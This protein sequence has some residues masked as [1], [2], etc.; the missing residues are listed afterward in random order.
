MLIDTHAHLNIMVKKKF[1]VPLTSYE[2][3]DA[4]TII[5]ECAHEGVTQFINVGT[6]LVESQNCIQ[7]AKKYKEVFAVVGIHPND[8][9]SSWHSDFKKIT[10]LIKQQEENRIVGIGECGLD[11]HYP[12][13]N[14][15]RQKDAFKAHIELALSYDLP[16]VVHTRD[17]LEETALILDL[18]KNEKLKGVIHCFSGDRP[19]AEFTMGLGFVLG[20]GGP[21][22]YPKNSTLR[23]IF[24]TIDLGKIVL[25]TDAPYLPI[26]A[27]RGKPN[28]PKYIKEIAQYLAELR[29]ISFDHVAKTTTR[30]AQKLFNLE[31]YA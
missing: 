15:P 9:T 13:T 31:H 8:L 26:Q 20:I 12:E 2:L 16:L 1:D 19:F 5:R 22:T 14:L 21:L 30:T 6:S 23:E 7:L 4:A 27:M 25:E 28:H 11:S 10:A 18:Y 24:A 29:G 17:A 3:D